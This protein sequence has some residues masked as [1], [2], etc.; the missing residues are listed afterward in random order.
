MH[1]ALELAMGLPR[2]SSSAAW[3]FAFFTPAEVRSSFMMPLSKLAERASQKND[4]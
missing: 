1:S 2:R 4:E 3:M